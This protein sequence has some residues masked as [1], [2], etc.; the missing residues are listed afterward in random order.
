MI[1]HN[2]PGLLELYPESPI[3]EFAEDLLE[4]SDFLVRASAAQTLSKLYEMNPK[5]KPLLLTAI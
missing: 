4:D 5:F 2:L 3:F 1:C